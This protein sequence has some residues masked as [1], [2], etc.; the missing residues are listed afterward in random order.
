MQKQNKSLISMQR[1]VGRIDPGR[2]FAGRFS[3]WIF[4][5]FNFQLST[6]NSSGQI[7]IIILLVIVVALTIG[8]SIA[9]SSLKG[10]QETAVLEESNRAF[11]AAEAGIEK[12]LLQLEQTGSATTI[13]DESLTGGAAIKQATATT[14]NALTLSRLEKDAVAQLD[15]E[16]PA[17]GAGAV[18]VKWETGSSLVIT[19]IYK[20]GDGNYQVDRWALNCD[21]SPGNNFTQIS[22]GADDICEFDISVDGA[23]DVALRIHA[24]YAD[25]SI[26]VEPAVGTSIPV[27]TTVVTATGQSG[28]AERTVQVE[29]SLPVPPSILDYVLFS[30]SGSLSK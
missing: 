23:S 5:T 16:C 24:L 18:T 25:T 6:F 19:R 7:L 28:E 21:H 13:T 2:G 26:S 8:L 29:R 9:G 4:S 12:L 15:L 1:D 14:K 3:G 27:Q 10:V 30:A 22:S 20:D 11:S 17:C